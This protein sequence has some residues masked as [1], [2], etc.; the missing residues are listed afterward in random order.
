MSAPDYATTDAIELEQTQP[1]PEPVSIRRLLAMKA[2]ERLSPERLRREAMKRG[3]RIRLRRREELLKRGLDL[4]LCAIVGLPAAIVVALCAL[5]VRMET[6]GSPIFFQQR[7]GKNGRRFRL[8]KLRTMVWNAEELKPSL[9]HLN[10]LP[11]P[12]F[13]ITKDPRV[14]RVGAWLRKTSLDEL[15]QLWNVLRGDMSLVGPR[16]TSF[17]SS[18]YALWH[19]E[20]LEATPGLTGLW[21]VLARGEVDFDER[22]RLDASYLRAYSVRLDLEILIATALV[23][24]AGRGG[25]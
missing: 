9:Q 10:E 22:L 21:Q 25:K 1:R 7:T 18:T 15:P 13:K 14:T 12:D 20:R 23:M 17:S 24:L 3:Y 5:A 6:P 2:C 8:W 19:T 11:W 4:L 16:P